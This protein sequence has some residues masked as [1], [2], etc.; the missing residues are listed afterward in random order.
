MIHFTV[1]WSFDGQDSTQDHQGGTYHWLKA[2][3]DSR[4]T[5]DIGWMYTRLLVEEGWRIPCHIW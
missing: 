1:R 4:G 3:A 5:P 2:V